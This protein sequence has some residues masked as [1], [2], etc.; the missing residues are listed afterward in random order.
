MPILDTVF[1][2]RNNI[3]KERLQICNDCEFYNKDNSKCKKCGCFMN[4]KTLIMSSSCPLN[5]WQPHKE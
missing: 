1:T 4:Y 2:R 3:S 5:K